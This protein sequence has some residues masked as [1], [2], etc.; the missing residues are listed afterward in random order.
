MLGSAIAATET[1]PLQ[2]LLLSRGVE[3]L[4]QDRAAG[5]GHLPWWTVTTACGETAAGV[6]ESG[7]HGAPVV[8]RPEGLGRPPTL[9]TRA[10]TLY[11]GV[12]HAA[13]PGWLWA[14]KRS[15]WFREK[16]KET[17]VLWSLDTDTD[18][19]LS[20]LADLT[21]GAVVLE[22]PT[23]ES[24]G[25]ALVAVGRT[26]HELR[27]RNGAPGAVDDL[28]RWTTTLE[29]AA[30]A[31]GPLPVPAVLD[32]PRRVVEVLRQVRS[33]VGMVGAAELT[34]RLDA[35]PWDGEQRL[36]SGLAARRAAAELTLGARRWPGLPAR[37]DSGVVPGRPVDTSDGALAE[38]VAS[39][40]SAADD[41]LATDPS[42]SLGLLADAMSVLF[43]R[44][45]HSEVP[46]S[47]LVDEPASTLAPL[48][49]SRAL[50]ALLDRG[51]EA[52]QQRRYE[53]AASPSPSHVLLARDG[54]PR[55]LV[56]TGAY[57]DFHRPVVRALR[58]VADVRTRDFARRHPLLRP[59]V[60]DDEVLD[61]LQAV[62]RR[63]SAR[64]DPSS[65]SDADLSGEEGEH[66]VDP[67]LQGLAAA[68]GVAAMLRWADVALL[69]WADR[70]SVWASH[71]CPEGTRLILRV[72]ALDALDPWLHL[73][74]WE[75]IE[76]VLVVSPAMNSLVRDLLG[77][78]GVEI[79]VETMHVLT[80]LREMDL[81]KEPG[82]RTTLGMV[83][84]GRQVKDPLWAL[85]LLERDPTW[86]LV[87]IGPDFAPNP[88]PATAPYVEEV[89]RRLASP[90]V[91]GRVHLVGRTGEVAEHLRR[92]GVILSTSVREGWH[93]G[94]VEG[95]CSGAVPVVRDWPLLSR[96]GGPA[97]LYPPEWVVPDLDAAED[98]IRRCTAEEAWERERCSAQEQAVALFDPD[99]VAEDYRRV[100]LGGPGA[101]SAPPGPR[102]RRRPG[103]GR[104][105]VHPRCRE[106]PRPEPRQDG[107]TRTP[108]GRGRAGAPAPSSP[109]R[110]PWLAGP[111]GPR[112]GRSRPGGAR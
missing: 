3:A 102:R 66:P 108:P 5:L 103:R 45:L 33:T 98:R 79:P 24:C 60:M 83:G 31:A 6:D 112:H 105:R 99:R 76:R 41:A 40:V 77:A 56:V 100:L 101:P 14:L 35:L 44:A 61:A 62:V 54:L 53:D 72:H 92:V 73:M 22:S 25:P 21:A 93:L 69:D 37:N 43:H 86:D 23:W 48:V 85:D 89:H 74:R 19:A 68:D 104:R 29:D 42:T 110:S 87:L 57:G 16:V 106:G 49:G 67:R 82:A 109:V 8:V 17:D 75:R 71:V 52:D 59:K 90:S 27:E 88:V 20:A 11:L 38:L 28:P 34:T 95:A 12:R 91:R 30:A 2:V 36:T 9:L 81:P 15:T 13:P 97:S 32:V 4:P 7:V 65:I 51:E 55:V 1:A 107:R 63:E 70:A 64:P 94:L 80:P 58:E 84:W 46:S 96:R 26:M 78:W 50:R 47:R 111:S 18:A 39:T 10:R